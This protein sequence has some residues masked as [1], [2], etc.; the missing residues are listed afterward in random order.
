MSK[1]NLTSLL[2]RLSRFTNVKVLD[3]NLCQ[4]VFEQDFKMMVDWIVRAAL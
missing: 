4:V 1:G 3:F 2:G